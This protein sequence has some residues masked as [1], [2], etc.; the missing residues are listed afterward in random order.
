LSGKDLP[1]NRHRETV[2]T[3]LLIL[4]PLFTGLKPGV[5]ETETIKLF[6][7]KL[8]SRDSCLPVF[9][10]LIRVHQRKSAANFLLVWLLL[11]CAN[12]R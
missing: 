9:S 4:A 5:N 11:I 3:V 8:L 2:E 6:E 12:L 7:A 10:H 1:R